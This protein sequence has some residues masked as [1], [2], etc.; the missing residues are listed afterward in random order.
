MLLLSMPS[1]ISFP[2]KLDHVLVKRTDFPKNI[3]ACPCLIY[4]GENTTSGSCFESVQPFLLGGI[5]VRFTVSKSSC[6]LWNNS[7]FDANAGQ[8]IGF[9]VIS[10]RSNQFVWNRIEVILM[11]L[12]HGVAHNKLSISERLLL[13][14]R[15]LEDSN[16]FDL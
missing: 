13:H 9:A 10:N 5:W 1:L 14:T 4:M 15:N 3:S 8:S 16:Q 6:S 11:S 2:F 7:I 12:M